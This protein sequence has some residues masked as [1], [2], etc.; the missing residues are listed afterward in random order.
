M[1]TGYK[2]LSTRDKPSSNAD[3]ALKPLGHIIE[4]SS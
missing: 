3:Y 4:L 2:M 1:E